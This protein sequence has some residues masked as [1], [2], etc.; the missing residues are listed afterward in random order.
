MGTRL[1]LG[2][3]RARTAVAVLHNL[4]PSAEVHTHV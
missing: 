1:I 4:R 3:T 2:A